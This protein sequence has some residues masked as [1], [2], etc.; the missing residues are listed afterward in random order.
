MF[1]LLPECDSIA[2]QNPLWSGDDEGRVT[3]VDLVQFNEDGVEIARE[4]MNFSLR[5]TGFWPTMGQLQTVVADVNARKRI[6]RP[7]P[8]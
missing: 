2:V 3:R 5:E 1:N 4:Q 8:E 7:P 6:R